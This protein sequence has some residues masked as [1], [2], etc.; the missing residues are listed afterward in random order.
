MTSCPRLKYFPQALG[1]LEAF[2]QVAGQQ[3]CSL[4]L[5]LAEWD[6]SREMV[7][8]WMVGGGGV[9]KGIGAREMV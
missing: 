5:F 6:W 1:L 4:Q 2:S 8:S 9:Q 3:Q 7:Q